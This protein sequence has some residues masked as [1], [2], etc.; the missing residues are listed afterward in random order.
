MNK[1]SIRLLSSPNGTENIQKTVDFLSR[2]SRNSPPERIE[3]LILRAPVTLVHNV[4]RPDAEKI[5]TALTKLGANAVFEPMDF[6]EEKIKK[7]PGEKPERVSV[8]K[9]RIIT[10]PQNETAEPITAK[11]KMGSRISHFLYPSGGR[12]G[13]AIVAIAALAIVVIVPVYT[14][15]NFAKIVALTGIGGK[16]AQA[17]RP[18][19][20]YTPPTGDLINHF[21]MNHAPYFDQRMAEGFAEAIAEYARLFPS[22]DKPSKIATSF[23]SKQLTYSTYILKFNVKTAS[24]SHDVEVTLTTDPDENRKNIDTL[25]KA[26]V[27]ILSKL[28]S[29]V[30]NPKTIQKTAG[31]A[32]KIVER[33]LSVLDAPSV[34]NA[35]AILGKTPQDPEALLGA[36]D[37]L[38]WMAYAKTTSDRYNLTDIL[39][40]QALSNHLIGSLFVDKDNPALKKSRALLWLGLDYPATALEEISGVTGADQEL[41]SLTIKRDIKGIEKAISDGNA[42][43]RLLTYLLVRASY[44]TDSQGE[45]T[46]RF[47]NLIHNHPDFLM[48]LEF[49][50]IN[51]GI[52]AGPEAPRFMREVIQSHLAA[53]KEIVDTTWMDKDKEFQIK[54]SGASSEEAAL[55]KWREIIKT[56]IE[57]SS[58]LKES[59]GILTYG[60]VKRY[61]TEEEMD[62]A[63]LYYLLENNSYSRLDAA[64]AAVESIGRVWPGSSVHMLAEINYQWNFE[65]FSQVEAVAKKAN[66]N[67]ADRRLT[68]ELARVYVSESESGAANGYKVMGALRKKTNP[69]A[70]AARDQVW[71]YQRHGYRPISNALIRRAIKLNPYG[72]LAYYSLEGT[73]EEFELVKAGDKLLGNSSNFLNAAAQW[74][75][76][77]G[78]EDETIEYFKRMIAVSPKSSHAPRELAQLYLDKKD[79]SNA[80]AIMKDYIKNDDGGWDYLSAKNRLAKIY[81]AQKKA[82]EAFNLMEDAKESGQGNSMIYYAQAAEMLGETL[83][84]ETYFKNTAQRYPS[85]SAPVDLAFFYL[86]QND[87]KTAVKTLHEYKRFNH[88]SYYFEEAIEFFKEAGKPEEVIA[89]LK[90]V[91]GGNPDK[92]V[93]YGLWEKLMKAKLYKLAA[94]VIKPQIT[95]PDNKQPYNFAV[96]Y[97]KAVDRGKL[98][99]TDAAFK[100]MMSALDS[101]PIAWEYFGHV[102]YKEGYYKESFDAIAAMSNADKNR[103]VVGLNL[104]ASAWRLGGS[105]PARKAIIEAKAK[106]YGI[107]EWQ[108]TLIS[109][110][111]EKAPAEDLLKKVEEL[112]MATEAYYAMAVDSLARGEKEKAEKFLIMCLE[113]KMTHHLEF[114]YA[115][116][117]LRKQ[118]VAG[119]D[120]K[121]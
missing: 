24:T 33:A 117:K 25:V 31:D 120:E 104:M 84:A 68:E 75:K 62:T 96:Y 48:G 29:D 57:K 90:E 58:S 13:I 73:P 101:D 1:G 102:L 71:H 11:T 35:L 80:E 52:L 87:R 76:K 99:D 3:S 72:H 67:T 105:D 60:F 34:L 70:G 78:R 27:E 38:S 98:L 110:Y 107:D 100:D 42:P 56:I 5:I 17:S 36:G 119:V 108:N 103:G 21:D 8:P 115:H 19:V 18:G 20:A 65:K 43:K 69:T 41:V 77:A 37:I 86:R 109:Y 26:F 28:E 50:L 10:P 2:I 49:V 16:P 88:H 85:G 118:K 113:T 92:W 66:V 39:S 114:T 44:D 74:A 30:K 83:L 59:G 15:G 32:K 93:W 4:A 64:L 121:S 111:L 9:K 106:E 7:T 53:L 63:Y 45:T 22:G 12:R 54:A 89:L 95:V 94:E 97:Y 40:A 23:T 91:E 51:G 61:L 79:F 82:K 46:V 14:K 55:D 47:S 81:L 112:S 6:P 116:W